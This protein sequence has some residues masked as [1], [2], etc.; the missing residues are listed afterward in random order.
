MVHGLTVMDTKRMDIRQCRLPDGHQV[1]DGARRR[2]RPEIYRLRRRWG[3]QVAPSPAAAEQPWRWS[4]KSTTARPPS[5][6]LSPSHLPATAPTWPRHIGPGGFRPL[7]PVASSMAAVSRFM[8]WARSR[9][10]KTTP[11]I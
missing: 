1:E 5:K 2:G 6:R 8:P 7:R 3:R 9:G 11:A 4:R 10:W